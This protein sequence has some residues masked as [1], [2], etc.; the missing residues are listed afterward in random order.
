MSKRKKSEFQSHQTGNVHHHTTASSAELEARYQTRG[1]TQKTVQKKGESIAIHLLTKCWSFLLFALFA[2]F[3][4]YILQEKNWDYLFCAQEHSLF[5]KDTT[6]FHNRMLFLGGFAQW[7]GCYLTQYFFHPWLG[8]W[9]LIGCWALLY[10]VLLRTFRT[11]FLASASA[12]LPL[13]ALL[14]SEVC[15]GYWVYYNKLEGYW[16]TETVC[17]LFMFASLWL[18]RVLGHVGRMVWLPLSVLLLYPLIGFWA[19]VGCAW[20]AL[21]SVS[22]ALQDPTR[23]VHS[24]PTR[25]VLSNPTRGVSS[26]LTRG[27]SSASVEGGHKKRSFTQTL[28]PL[29]VAFGCILVVPLCYYQFFGRNRLED[30]WL[31]NF[32]IF[33]NDNVTSPLLSI[34]FVIV[35]LSPAVI[36]LFRFC[37][38]GWLKKRVGQCVV[39]VCCLVLMAWGVERANYDDYNFHAEIRMYQ[40]IDRCDYQT[41]LDECAALPGKP[42]RQMVLSKDIALM[43]LGGIGDRMFKFDNRGEQIHVFDSLK[44][45]LVQTCGPQIYYNYGKANFACRWAIEDGVEFGFDADDLKMLVRTSMMSG[46]LRAARKYID[47]LLNTT[48]HQEWAEKWLA[49]L[50]DS[51]LYQRHPEYRNIAPLRGFFNRLDG[52]EGLVEIYII[53]YFAHTSKREPKFQEQCLIFSLVQKDISLFWPKF[54]AYASLHEQSIMPIHYQE[55]AY[56][57][58]QLEPQRI[59][60]SKMPFDQELIIQRYAN[61]MEATQRMVQNGMTEE[62]IGDATYSLYGDTFWWF[63]YFCRNIHT[64]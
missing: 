47:I 30:L 45:H 22:H 4:F 20:M 16:F 51:T 64:Y 10:F 33:Q 24:D 35:A 54:F 12:L 44:V 42:T 56:L 14:A 62:Q 58:G 29:L 38:R 61:F 28:V 26:D 2:L 7:L 53:N 59:D 41:V 55:A 48:F 63:Y 17:V 31:I 37:E 8:S 18:Y 57:Y 50:N 15:I 34:P 25:G 3:A 9:I 49:M 5:V 40:A 46:E 1:Q 39:G 43:N 11:S 60:I 32:P 21:L 23:G 52:D 36:L 6:F 13:F 19:L 27:V